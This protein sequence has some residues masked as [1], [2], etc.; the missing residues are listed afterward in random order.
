M[1]TNY[2]PGDCIVCKIGYSK[3]L[4]ADSKNFEYTQPFD[5]ICVVDTNYLILV[6]QDIHLVGSFTLTAKHCKK[7]NIDKKFSDA[8]TCF[9]SDDDVV[10]VRSRMTGLCCSK[11]AIRYEYAE[12]NRFDADGNGILVCWLCKSYPH[13]K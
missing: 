5:I 2:H 8:E 7:F 10:S 6:P 12:I 4:G 9:I 11:C 1:T 13:Y 3:I